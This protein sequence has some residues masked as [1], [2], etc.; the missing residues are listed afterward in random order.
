MTQTGLRPSTPDNRLD[1]N[2]YTDTWRLPL[3]GRLNS[4]ALTGARLDRYDHPH[5]HQPKLL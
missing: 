4:Y 1:F 5:R 2:T 3:R